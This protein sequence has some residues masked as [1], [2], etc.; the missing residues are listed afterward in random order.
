MKN[1][2][3]LMEM[4][5]PE[6]LAELGVKQVNVDNRRLFYMTSSGQLFN[7]EDYAAA[8]AHEYNWLMNDEDSEK[9]SDE[10]A[11]NEQKDCCVDDCL[12]CDKAC[13]SKAP[14]VEETNSDK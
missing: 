2:D 8:Y 13:P 4:M 9:A 14:P 6:L 1:Y 10:V 5:T 3:K 7:I 12:E 11:Q